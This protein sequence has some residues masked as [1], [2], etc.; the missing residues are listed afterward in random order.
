[1]K[2]QRTHTLEN[3]HE[4]RTYSMYSWIVMFSAQLIK[5]HIST[6][7]ESRCARLTDSLQTRGGKTRKI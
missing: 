3:Y 1:M 6:L 2:T 5:N 7:S 4:R